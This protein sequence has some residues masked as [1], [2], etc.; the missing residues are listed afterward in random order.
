MNPTVRRNFSRASARWTGC[1]ARRSGRGPG[2]P[3]ALP[4][5]GEQPAEHEHEGEDDGEP[6]EPREIVETAAVEARDRVVRAGAGSGS[7][8]ASI[9]ALVARRR[10]SSPSGSR[11]GE[12]GAR[13]AITP[14]IAEP[15]HPPV[16]GEEAASGPRRLAPAVARWGRRS[17][18]PRVAPSGCR[19]RR[20]ASRRSSRSGRVDLDEGQGGHRDQRLADADEHVDPDHRRQRHL[21]RRSCP[22]RSQLERTWRRR[23]R[24]PTARPRRRP[25]GSAPAPRRRG[26]GTGP[27]RSRSRRCVPDDAHVEDVRAHHDEA[28]VLEDQRLD[29]DD[30]GHHQRAAHGPRRTAAR[31]PPRRWPDVPPTTWKLNI[32]A[33]KMKAAMTPISG[34]ARSSSVGSS[35]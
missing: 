21:E 22:D 33:A 19:R 9:E 7:C 2:R 15:D 5:A 11:R 20:R 25:P 30:A 35:A 17:V 1:R 4:P 3:P 12:G 26:A 6:D 13:T 10:E 34:I 32:W 16:A 29:G 31:T 8:A 24:R 23:R 27:G 14:A 28:A 18:M